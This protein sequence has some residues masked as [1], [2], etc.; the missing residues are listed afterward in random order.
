MNRKDQIITYLM[1]IFIVGGVICLGMIVMYFASLWQTKSEINKLK[2]SYDTK[3]VQ[4]DKE[5]DHSAKIDFLREENVDTA[6]WIYIKGSEIDLPV[7]YTPDRPEHYLRKDFQQKYSLRGLPFVDGRGQILPMDNNTIIYGHNMQDG[8]MFSGLIAYKNK[9]TWDKNNEIDLLTEDGHK[10]YK[11]FAVLEAKIGDNFPYYDYVGQL[12]ENRFNEYVSKCK[13]KALYDTQI[14]PIYG[15][16][17][18]TLSTC[19]GDDAA[20]R[21]AV[22][23]VLQRKLKD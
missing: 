11:V 6:F 15:D 7:M 10:Y 22:I 2:E 1:N 12:D 4:S 17:L 9:D 14:T 3:A 23:G 19:D 20:G 8:S 16:E 13:Q 5:D 18:I 21:L